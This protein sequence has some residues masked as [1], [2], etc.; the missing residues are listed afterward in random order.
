MQKV[1]F[2]IPDIV[3]PIGSGKDFL[4]NILKGKSGISFSD[5]FIDN[6]SI[7]VGK[8]DDLSITVKD[9]PACLQVKEFNTRAVFMLMPLLINLK[10]KVE[11]LKKIYGKD[12]V[13]VSIGTT[14]PGLDENLDAFYYYCKTGDFSKYSAH[15]NSLYNLAR[16]CSLF[17]NIQGPAFT[18]STACTSGLKAIIQGYRL[19]KAGICDAVLCGGSD[20]LNSLTI[21]GFNNLSILSNAQSIPFSKNRDGVNL[22]EA[23]TL[24]FLTKEQI[25][26]NIIIKS[27]SSNNDAFSMTKQ[28]TNSQ[29]SIK[30]LEDLKNG[31]NGENIDYINL[32][33]TGTISNDIV[34]ANSVNKVFGGN[35]L[36]SGIKQLIGHTLGVAG[37]VETAL[38]VLLVDKKNTNLPPHIY[39]NNYDDNLAKINLVTKEN[40][41][42]YQIKN[43]AS[44]NFAFGGD[45][46]AIAVGQ[47]T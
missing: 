1:Y 40:K 31:M 42:I 11:E 17:Y 45:N 28:D 38:C 43:V 22:G 27:F 15:R 19:I 7:P 26:S 47:D 41:N 16:F 36:C 2:S 10:D 23:A 18:I 32:H 24:F 9:L 5:K 3:S 4:P 25:Y 30:L 20:C 39:D 34:E 14:N 46:C 8:I 12:R 44:I 29:Y 13:G 35:I 21:N 37:S 33:A 6:M